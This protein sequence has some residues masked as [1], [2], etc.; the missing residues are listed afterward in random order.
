MILIEYDH[1]SLMLKMS[2]DFEFCYIEGC[3]LLKQTKREEELCFL[4]VLTMILHSCE[5]PQCC[6]VSVACFQGNIYSFIEKK[7]Y[8]VAKTAQSAPFQHSWP[9]LMILIGV[10]TLASINYLAVPPHSYAKSEPLYY[11][12]TLQH[13]GDH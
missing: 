9:A 3:G 11:Y 5:V 13:L 7:I 2:S 8:V 12:A 10:I 1:F 4:F 6:T